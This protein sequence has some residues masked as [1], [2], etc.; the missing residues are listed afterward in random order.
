MTTRHPDRMHANQRT[1]ILYFL[2]LIVFACVVASWSE[3]VAS[4]GDAP[5][6]SYQP[7]VVL[8]YTDYFQKNEGD[9]FRPYDWDGDM[10]D[11]NA[12]SNVL[13]FAWRY[14][15]PHPTYNGETS[16]IRQP[17][18]SRTDCED[19]E[20]DEV[21]CT[22][23]VSDCHHDWQDDPPPIHQTVKLVCSGVRLCGFEN[24]EDCCR[25]YDTVSP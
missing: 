18:G 8:R 6:A 24:A 25:P 19:A 14:L 16:L 12:W 10:L 2:S 7:P 21:I 1:E 20:A 22:V 9:Y 13:W 17:C 3:P 4:A 15:W 11:Y 23:A 5:E